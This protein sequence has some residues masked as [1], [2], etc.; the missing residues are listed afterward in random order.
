MAGF[1]CRQE[2][3]CLFAN[4]ADWSAYSG[5]V[6]GYSDT[7]GIGISTNKPSGAVRIT[8]VIIAVRR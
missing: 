4:T 8:W 2:N 6:S 7:G 1:S 5:L 3:C